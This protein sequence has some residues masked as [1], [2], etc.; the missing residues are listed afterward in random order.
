MI[1]GAAGTGGIQAQIARAQGGGIQA[2][3]ARAQGGGMQAEIARAQGGVRA[4]VRRS[5]DEGRA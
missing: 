1:M 2:Q 5:A 4:W 3:I